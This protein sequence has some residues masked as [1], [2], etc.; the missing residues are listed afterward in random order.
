[1]GLNVVAA[2]GQE[3]VLGAIA[4]LVN[5]DLNEPVQPAV[6]ELVGDDPL[7]R[8]ADRSSRDQH[9]AS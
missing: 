5:A 7:E 1:M 8:L 9:S 3:L 4:D 2:A 6:I